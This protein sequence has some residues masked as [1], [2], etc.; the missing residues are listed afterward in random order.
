[1]TFDQYCEGTLGKENANKLLA[2][3]DEKELE[4]QRDAFDYGR[5]SVVMEVADYFGWSHTFEE[6]D[7]ILHKIEVLPI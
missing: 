3:I 7:R 1:M 5:R 4:R 6:I 2:G